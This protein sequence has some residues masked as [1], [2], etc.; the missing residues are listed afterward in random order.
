V[1]LRCD[2]VRPQSA[3]T[4][5]L[6][7]PRTAV[8]SSRSGFRSSH[9][10]DVRSAAEGRWRSPGGAGAPSQGAPSLGWG[11][12]AA[13]P[14]VTPSHIRTSALP[15]SGSSAPTSRAIAFGDPSAP[16]CAPNYA[17]RCIGGTRFSETVACALL[18]ARCGAISRIHQPDGQGRLNIDPV[19]PVGTEPRVAGWSRQLERAQRAR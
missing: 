2:T 15:R 13:D 6:L 12:F 7:A 18:S 19:A 11:S 4:H 9:I 10:F 8:E 3:Y 1:R 16:P 17:G 5:L 14:I